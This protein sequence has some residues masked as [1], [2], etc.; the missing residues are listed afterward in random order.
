MYREEKLSV[1]LLTVSYWD[2]FSE[3]ENYLYKIFKIIIRVPPDE[4][5]GVGVR[6]C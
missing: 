5:G 1:G 6:P 2:S 3:H 4:S